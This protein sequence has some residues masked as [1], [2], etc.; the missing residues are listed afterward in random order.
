[1]DLNQLV[2]AVQACLIPDANTRKAG[3]EAL[4]QVI[5]LRLLYMRLLADVCNEQFPPHAYHK[6]SMV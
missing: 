3:E 2:G 6:D 5:L 4:K 1:M